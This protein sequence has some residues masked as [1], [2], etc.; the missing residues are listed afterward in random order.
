MEKRD[1]LTRAH[2]PRRVDVNATGVC[3]LTSGRMTRPTR[4]S[5]VKDRLLL[6]VGGSYYTEAH[7]PC[8]DPIWS[9]LETRPTTQYR[10]GRSGYDPEPCLVLPCCTL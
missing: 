7:N 8:Q 10:P 1:T 5:V 4:Y 9:G 2:V 6:P 3:P